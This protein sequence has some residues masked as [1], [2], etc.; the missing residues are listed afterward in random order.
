MSTLSVRNI[1]TPDGTPVAFPTGVIF[2]V[3]TGG[4]V[5]NIGTPGSPGFGAG[6]CPGPLPAGVYPLP[7]CNDPLHDNYGNY[8]DASGSVMV[9][10]PAFYYK[11]GTGANG[12][13]INAVDIK[14]HSYFDSVGTANAAGYALHRAF[15]DGG[16]QAGFFVDKYI[17]SNSLGPNV[18][19]GIMVSVKN[20][21][22][23]DTDGSQS[24]VASIAGVSVNDFG[25]V[26]TAAKSRGANYHAASIF[27][28]KALAM[29]SYAHA[30]ASTS[31][32]YC[33]WYHATNNFPKGCNNNALGDTHGTLGDVDDAALTFVS[34]G[35][36]TYPSKPKTGSANLFARTTH[37]GQNC[38]VA[39]LNGAMWE[40]GFGL[41]SDGTN[42][43]ALK[44]TK[45]MRDLIG[46]AATSA[47]S[48]FGAAGIAA[49]YDNLGAT[50]GQALASDGL[51][52]FG[53]ASQ[54]FDAATSGTL[55]QATGC[56]IPIN[57]G[58]TNPF[59]GDAFGDYRPV[60]MC[61]MVGANWNYG[62]KAGVWALSLYLVRTYD[63]VNVSGRAALYL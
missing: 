29:L 35:H 42:Y 48:L 39:D 23:L 54:V 19:G 21:I 5:N 58:G 28:Y 45:R 47:N 34:A 62:S 9:W 10:V 16:E 30:Q 14:R 50:V 13:A 33:A 12:L 4:A 59:G 22:P 24:G 60:E 18:V 2:G 55:W 57:V 17:G 36:V 27:I 46:S 1:T 56:G 40:T 49:N 11:W 53:S 38:G 15:Y 8:A 26:Q 6:I 32:A 7:G 63:S 52:Y 51:K 44:T 25:N 31:T 61:P 20:G 43:Y 3:T 37:N 41:T